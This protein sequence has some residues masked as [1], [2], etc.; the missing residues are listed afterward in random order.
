MSGLLSADS[1]SGRVALVTGASRGIGAAIAA[2]LAGAGATVIGTATSASGAD[3]ISDALGGGGR[4]A[5]LDVTSEDS[6]VAVLK[7][8][9][10]NEGAPTIVVNN[11]GITR[12]NLLMRM[13]AEDWDSVFPQ[14]SQAYTAFAKPASAA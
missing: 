14:I 10:D 6:V 11:A 4:G 5:A 9:Q 13:K 12:D 7:D 8:I 1:L 3:A 2:T